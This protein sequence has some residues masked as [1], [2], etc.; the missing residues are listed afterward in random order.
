MA[1]FLPWNPSESGQR[2]NLGGKKNGHGWMFG[3]LFC[4]SFVYPGQILPIHQFLLR[5]G[6]IIIK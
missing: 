5:N 6:D 1:E 3:G 4:Y 2:L